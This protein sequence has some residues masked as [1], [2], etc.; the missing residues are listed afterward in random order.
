MIERETR[1]GLRGRGKSRDG[2]KKPAAFWGRRR[3]KEH[4]REASRGWEE[5]VVGCVLA[6]L[7]GD[8]EGGEDDSF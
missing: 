8:E 5:S 7:E 2:K 4:E 1:K 6:K 3:R